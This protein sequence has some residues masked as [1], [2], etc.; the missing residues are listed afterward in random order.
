MPGEVMLVYVGYIL[1]AAVPLIALWLIV[2]IVRSLERMAAA[3][4]RVADAIRT[5]GRGMEVPGGHG[6]DVPRGW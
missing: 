4:E 1:M 5:G 2:R 3:Q 6:T